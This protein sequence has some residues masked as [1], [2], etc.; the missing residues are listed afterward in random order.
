MHEMVRVQ[1]HLALGQTAIAALMIDPASSQSLAHES[2]SATIRCV[3]DDDDKEAVSAS[4]ESAALVLKVMKDHP[5]IDVNQH[6]VDLTAASLEIL[7][8]R[9][10]CQME[11]DYDSEA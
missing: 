1:A 4:I 7:E 10:V 6:I 3:L 11:D 8:G 9:A 2:L 5:T